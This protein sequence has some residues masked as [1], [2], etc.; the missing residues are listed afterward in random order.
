MKKI[1]LLTLISCFVVSGLVYASPVGNPAKPLLANEEMPFSAGAEFDFVFERELDVSDVDMSVENL[2]IYA[3]KLAYTLE[4][5]AELYCLLGVANGELSIESGGVDLS[6][7]TETAFAWG[8]GATVFLYE[9]DNGIRLG[10]D[11]NFRNTAPSLDEV[12]VDL[13]YSEWQIALGVSKQI[14]QF[15]PY[16]GIKYSDVKAELTIPGVGS[17]DTGSDNIF[18]IF[19]GCDFLANENISVGIEGRF[20]DETALAIRGMYRF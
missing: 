17:E 10:V 5:R 4:K 12:D 11:G 7:D 13:E 14:D 9:F 15:V 1:L 16:G 3:A 18:G 2:N 20:I 6:I 19:V 8:I